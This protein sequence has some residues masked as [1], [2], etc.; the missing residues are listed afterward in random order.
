VKADNQILEKAT[1]RALCGKGAHAETPTVFSEMN[2]KL[3]GTRP[4][5]A[6]HSLFQLLNH[7]IYWQDWA[8]KWLDGEQPPIPKHAPGSWPGGA[9]PASAEEWKQTVARFENGLDRLERQA[10]E[11]DLLSKRGSK[12]RLEMLQTIAGHNSHHAGQAV[13]LRQMLGAWPP[14]SGGLTW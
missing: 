1:R 5:G 9:E 7:M 10:G 14:P 6:P 12:S 3:A 13:L 11:G 8:V 4:A 2:W